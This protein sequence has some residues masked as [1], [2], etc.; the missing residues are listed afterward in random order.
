MEPLRWE[1]VAVGL[2][3]FDFTASLYSCVI[4]GFAEGG[5][6]NLNSPFFFYFYLSM[7]F[8]VC[9]VDFRN[10]LLVATFYLIVGSNLVFYKFSRST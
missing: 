2:K 8:F 7:P 9:S 1:T 6:F 5:G 3:L 10:N 4:I